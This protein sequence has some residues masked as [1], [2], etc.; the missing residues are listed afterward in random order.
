MNARHCFLIWF[1][2][3][4]VLSSYGHCLA[5]DRATTLTV[6]EIVLKINEIGQEKVAV[7]C[8]KACVPALSELQ[9][10]KPRIIMDFAGVSFI[11][12]KYRNVPVSG[13]YVKQ[14]RSYLDRATKKLRIVLDMDTSK[15][16]VVHPTQ[17]QTANVYSLVISEGPRVKDTSA[18][19]SPV[20]ETNRKSIVDQERRQTD[21]D[22]KPA[23]TAVKQAPVSVDIITEDKISLERGRS[24]MNAGN[25][26]GAINTFTELIAKNPKDNLP[27]RLRGNAY[28]NLGDRQKAAADWI[29]AARLGDEIVQSYLDYMK[30]NW[31]EAPK[32]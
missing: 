26:S 9:G 23:E 3:F 20:T 27:Y 22:V 19:K 7:V 1:A 2:V 28:Q 12:P 31:K 10:E 8:S 29:T 17:D 32:P 21:K 24:Q 30:I 6:K 4:F 11:E 14:L 5:K 16:Y 13:K 25:Y 15:R 18:E